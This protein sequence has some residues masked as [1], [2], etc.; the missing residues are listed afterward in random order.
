MFC[1]RGGSRVI[2]ASAAAKLLACILGNQ[3]GAWAVTVGGG[4]WLQV[5]S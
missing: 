2:P 4:A 3:T 1:G 5:G